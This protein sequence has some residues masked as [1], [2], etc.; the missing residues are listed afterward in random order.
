MKK[1]L[2]LFI[3][4]LTFLVSGCGNK[5]S[6]NEFIKIASTGTPQEVEAAVKQVGNIN[7]TFTMKTKV[8]PTKF[9]VMH[10]VAQK[11]KYPEV[12]DILIK[13][14]AEK[15]IENQLAEG[16]PIDIAAEMN[17]NEGIVTA[18]YNNG[19]KSAQN[20]YRR[21][22]FAA[23]KNPNP[24]ILEEVLKIDEIRNAAVNSPAK[25]TAIT[26]AKAAKSTDEKLQILY[27]YGFSD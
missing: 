5:I 8:G 1:L 10:Y 15:N 11:T 9:H 6:F 2:P 27:N 22:I 25:K 12:I 20:D 26:Y 7:K 16:N 4:C 13:N 19:A 23:I 14:G 17:P 3:I 24:A 21:V 18:L